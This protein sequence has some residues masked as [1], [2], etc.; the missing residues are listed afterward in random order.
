MHLFEFTVR[1]R[2]ADG[3]VEIVVTDADGT[4]VSRETS[5]ILGTP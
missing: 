4:I 3:Q 1:G 2:V 5:R